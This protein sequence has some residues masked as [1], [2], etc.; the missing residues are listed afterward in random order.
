MSS[1]TE[2]SVDFGTGREEGGC[3]LALDLGRSCRG[4]GT[5][6]RQRRTVVIC[7][8]FVHLLVFRLGDFFL[9]ITEICLHLSSFFFFCGKLVSLFVFVMF[10]ALFGRPPGPG[11]TTVQNQPTRHQGKVRP[12]KQALAFAEASSPGQ[13]PP[14]VTAPP[15]SPHSCAS[16]LSV[17][18]TSTLS[19][20]SLPRARR[21]RRRDGHLRRALPRGDAPQR[22]L[23]HLCRRR[24]LRGR[25]G[26]P[27]P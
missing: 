2:G 13:R 21:R 19:T 23:R 1:Y 10:W 14:D 16:P 27:Y 20:T 24:R 4:E 12:N 25:A 17:G 22:R 3:A 15:P 18:S 7:V 8:A 5:A 6:T 26:T 9:F 11:S